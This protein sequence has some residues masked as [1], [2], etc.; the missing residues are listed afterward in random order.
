[1]IFHCEAPR[2]GSRV[3]GKV[4]R[5]VSKAYRRAVGKDWAVDSVSIQKTGRTRQALEGKPGSSGWDLLGFADGSRLA[6]FAG[7]ISAIPNLPPEIPK[8]GSIRGVE[9]SFEGSG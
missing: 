6:G 8:L 4:M 2:D 3:K 1:M 5:N 9:A 7:G